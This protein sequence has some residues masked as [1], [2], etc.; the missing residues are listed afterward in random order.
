MN[1]ITVVAGAE[2]LVIG[3]VEAAPGIMA[4]GDAAQAANGYLAAAA[5]NSIAWENIYDFTKGV[6]NPRAFPVTPGGV[7]GGFSGAILRALLG[8]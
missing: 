3:G 5:E 8:Q 2:A 7:L 6:A 4:A 1:V